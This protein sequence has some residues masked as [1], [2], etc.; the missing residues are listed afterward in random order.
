MLSNMF[1]Q[2][3]VQQY[4][5]VDPGFNGL[6]LSDASFLKDLQYKID[7]KNP[8]VILSYIEYDDSDQHGTP[9][10]E[11]WNLLQDCADRGTLVI[12]ADT[13][14]N[15]RWNHRPL[16]LPIHHCRG[17]LSFACNCDMVGDMLVEWAWSNA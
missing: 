9:D 11:Y 7:V 5:S 15:A 8:S 16:A 4:V 3:M 2:T 14:Y 6:N 10:I 13:Q 12:A 1:A 17:D